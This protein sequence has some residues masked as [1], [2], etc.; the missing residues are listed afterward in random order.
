[1]TDQ[2]KTNNSSWNAEQL[3][4]MRYLVVNRLAQAII[5]Q[6]KKKSDNIKDW[7]G[8]DAAEDTRSSRGCKEMQQVPDFGEDLSDDDGSDD[9]DEFENTMNQ[10]AEEEDEAAFHR[11]DAFPLVPQLDDGEVPQYQQ[12]PDL[13][14]AF[15]NE[16]MLDPEEFEAV[17]GQAQVHAPPQQDVP[18]FL[19]E[20]QV[21]YEQ[22][23]LNTNAAHAG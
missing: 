17:L 6:L 10:G 8:R 20:G 12:S 19:Y 21:L 2:N 7:I 9:E 22:I 23:L 18:D 13:F 3:L 15:A 14:D 11:V 1:M 4:P 16:L 5:F